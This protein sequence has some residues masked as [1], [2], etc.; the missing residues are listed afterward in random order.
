MNASEPAKTW[1]YYAVK[2][3]KRYGMFKLLISKYILIEVKFNISNSY[4]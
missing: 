3:I 2:I 1:K 4:R